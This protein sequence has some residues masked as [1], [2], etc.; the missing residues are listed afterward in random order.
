MVPI[1][2]IVADDHTL[3]RDGLKKMLSLERD[4]LVVGEAGRGDEV[5]KAVERG[6]PDVLLLDLRMPKGDLVQTLLDVR[7][8]SPMTKVLI[9]TAYAEEESIMNAAKGGARGYL[10]KGADLL[11]LLQAIKKVH[12][13]GLW[14]DE[15]LPAAGTFEEIALGQIEPDKATQ[16]DEVVETLTRRELEILQLVAEGMTNEEIGK[17]IFISEKTVKTHLTNI[18]DKLKVNNRFKAALMIMGGRGKQ[19]RQHSW[20]E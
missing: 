5:V 9:L 19:Q 13:G 2:I 3:F 6:R 20:A 4:V 8:R 15:E 10:L 16:H 14:I 12:G 1:K 7:E 18:F 17:R 11:T